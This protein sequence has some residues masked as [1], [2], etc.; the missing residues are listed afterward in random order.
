MTTT[1]TFWS[2]SVVVTFDTLAYGPRVTALDD[3]TFVMAW[4]NGT[5]IFARHLSEFGSF[6]GGNLLTTISGTAQAVSTPII[7]QQTG[8]VVLNYQY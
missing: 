3:G 7:T 2:G 6:T 4:E 8:S 1:P 5:D